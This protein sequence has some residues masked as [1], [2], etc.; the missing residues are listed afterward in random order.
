MFKKIWALLATV[1]VLAS[2]YFSNATP[3]I[4]A[5]S[6]IG[7]IFVLGV[8]FKKAWTNLLGAALALIYAYLSFS[9]GYNANA[10][11]NLV[12]LFPLQVLA[13]FFWR[14]E[15]GRTFELSQ[16]IKK[17]FVFLIPICMVIA[18]YAAYLSGSS[19]F[20]HD[21]ISSI[22]V[23]FATLMLMMKVKEQ[24]YAWIPYNAIEVFMWFIAASFHPEMLAIFVMRSIFLVNSLIGWNE[25]RVRKS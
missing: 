23:I 12:I 17:W 22:L 21:G 14:K 6:L 19:L 9:A 8:A 16:C 10:A 20:I 18:V 24:W 7:V 4:T 5:A 11:I 13:F 3:L 1:G 2:C 25:W 15:N